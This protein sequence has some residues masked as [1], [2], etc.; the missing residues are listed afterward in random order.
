MDKKTKG[1]SKDEMHKKKEEAR[2][3]EENDLLDIIKDNEKKFVS[4]QNNKE[5]EFY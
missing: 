3:K 4:I 5:Y 2:L 1:L